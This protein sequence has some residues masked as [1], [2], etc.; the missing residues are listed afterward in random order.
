MQAYMWSISPVFR[1]H[2]VWLPGYI[3]L[4]GMFHTIVHDPLMSTRILNLILGTL[5]VPVFYL[6]IRRIFDDTSA[7][8]GAALLAVFPFH[9]KLSVTSLTEISFLFEIILGTFLII[10]AAMTDSWPRYGCLIFSVLMFGLASLT[11]YEVWI[12]LPL[13]PVYFLV[14]TGRFFQ[15]AFLAAGLALFPIVW[16][17]ASFFETGS[18]LP[19]YG[20]AMFEA[21][22]GTNFAGALKN[23][24]RFSVSY[25][26][27]ILPLLAAGGFLLLLT[28][29]PQKKLSVDRLLYLAIVCL[30]GMFCVKFAID[31]GSSLWM[32]YL[33][34]FFV[35]IL[36]LGTFVMS[37][38]LRKYPLIIMLVVLLSAAPPFVSQALK[39]NEVVTRKAAPGIEKVGRWL[40]DS[41][42]RDAPILLTVMKW[43]STYLPL[44]RPEIAFRYLIVSDWLQDANLQD[45]IATFQPQVL[46]TRD[47]E[48][49]YIARLEKLFGKKIM[50]ED[51]LIYNQDNY[52]A[53]DLR[54]LSSAVEPSYE[55]AD[56][57]VPVGPD[58]LHEIRKNF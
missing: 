37:R 12:L 29:T 41:P 6:L 17:V 36:P 21:G 34:F 3:Y 18:F 27:W 50:V 11:R 5:S 28:D 47:G 43:D 31:R 7:L 54:G 19:A 45:F 38:Y 15:S 24:M 20:A 33:L 46:I 4:S 55:P 10:K 53:Y 56:R 57:T 44:Y 14:K 40:A 26:G 9:I 49:K 58:F 52:K 13:F 2:V 35:I 1:P 22:A 8:I 39:L 32:R 48:Q 42:F 25:L 16:M 30:T 51:R 23:I